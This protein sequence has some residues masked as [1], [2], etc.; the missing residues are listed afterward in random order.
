[1]AFGK[2]EATDKG[3][4]FETAWREFGEEIGHPL[5][6][7][8]ETREKCK[9]LDN[10]T[11]EGGMLFVLEV[12]STANVSQQQCNYTDGKTREVKWWDACEV[13]RLEY[14]RWSTYNLLKVLVNDNMEKLD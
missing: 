13:T 4:A 10:T 2:A 14:V 5:T 6:G 12:D 3:V 9:Q 8:E 1:M 7:K 11:Q